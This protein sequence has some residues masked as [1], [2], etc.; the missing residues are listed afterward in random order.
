MLLPIQ[1]LIVAGLSL[2]LLACSSEDNSEPPAPL[3][4]I[5]QAVNLQID[6]ST[7]TDAVA[8]GA[9]FDMRPLVIGDQVLSIDI[10]GVVKSINLENGRVKWRFET[11]VAAIT[12][13]VG[14]QDVVVATSGDGDLVIFKLLDRGLEKRWAIQLKG[15]I[16]AIPALHQDLI[17]VRTV[18]GK[19]SA[20]SLADGVIQW[21]VSRRIPVLSLTGNS[22][23][24]VFKDTVIVGFDD[25]KIAA[26]DHKNGQMIWETVVSHSVGR[27]EIERLVDIDG[28]FTL[29]DGIIYVSTYQGKLAAIQALNG[30]VLWSRKFSSYQSIVADADALYISGDL[31]HLWSIDRRSGSAFWKQDVLHARKITAPQ[32]VDGQIVVADFE[33]YVHWFDKA[34]GSLIGRIKPSNSGHISQPLQWRNNVLVFDS[35]GQLSSLARP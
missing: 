11:G 17:F 25:G 27:T 23:P 8:S 32:I 24:L 31:S 7:D 13:L 35:D 15:E 22:S 19:L 30:N 28:Q 9:S 12:G 33:G 34:D 10:E 21:T 5:K 26:F 14:N 3:T 16:R 4:E 29:K 18:A 6:W 1:T 2:L 20:V